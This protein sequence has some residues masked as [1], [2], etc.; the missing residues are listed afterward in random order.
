VGIALYSTLEGNN[1]GEGVF[2][3]GH[4]APGPEEHNGSSWDRVS[5]HFFETIGQPVLRGRSLTEQDTATSQWVA[6]VNQAF[7]KKFFP[8][9]DPMGRHFGNMDQKYSSAF[10][11]VGIVADAKY[12][13]PREPVRTMYF[14]PLNQ[15]LAGLTEANTIMAEGRGLYIN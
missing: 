2:V 5:P 10:E 15:K 12:T 8:K 4:P 3:Q 9:E 7:V 11:I 1:W 6:V 14:R 13:N